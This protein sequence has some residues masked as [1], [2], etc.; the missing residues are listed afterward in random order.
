[1]GCNCGKKKKGAV[2]VFSTE[3]QRRIAAQRNVVV[4]TAGP[5]NGKKADWNTTNQ[6]STAPHSH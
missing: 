3:E 5:S 2:S 1:M 4:T 6:Q